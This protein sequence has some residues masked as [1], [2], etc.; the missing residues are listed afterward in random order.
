MASVIYLIVI[1][2]LNK[3][4]PMVLAAIGTRFSELDPA[5]SEGYDGQF[6]YYIATNPS[7][8]APHLDVPAYRYQR[9][10]YPLL[11]RFLAFGQRDLIPWIMPLVNIL[12]LTAGT[13]FVERLLKGFG[14]TS[15]YAIV[16]GL[17]PG[18]FLSLRLDLNEPL[19]YAL[20][21]GGILAFERGKE[22]SGAILFGLAG[23]AKEQALLFA[24]G[25]ALAFIAR[26]K[27]EELKELALFSFFPMA[28][29]QGAL[30][31]RF[32]DFGIGS[33]GAGATPFSIIPYGGL[34]QI[35]FL[36]IRALLLWLIILGPGALFP[37]IALSYLSAVR[38]VKGER[39]PLA[40]STLLH[41]LILAFLPF[42]T[43]REFLAILRFLSGLAAAT[44]L[45]G[46]LIRSRRM[47]NYSL[48]WLSYLVFIF[49]V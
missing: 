23:L 9:I 24:G 14:V 19:A 20:V 31:L 40:F 21:C 3:W 41:A 43:W 48:F 39:H 2:G 8:A 28:V 5:G 47:L 16:Y 22:R 6:A 26:R 46:A 27:W 34:L 15:Y 7:G 12:A 11:C 44:I 42:S 35:G 17:F 45:Y 37:S 25:Y 36:N 49:K 10:L 13:Y 29:L 38:L 4:D 33:G 1:L 32:G 18:L 30:W